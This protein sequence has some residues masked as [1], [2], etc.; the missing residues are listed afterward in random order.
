MSDVVKNTTCPPEALPPK[1][2]G[3]AGGTSELN[4][5]YNDK[6]DTIL[7]LPTCLRKFNRVNRDTDKEISLEKLELSVRS[8]TIPDISIPATK[9]A[10]GVGSHTEAGTKYDDFPDIDIQFKMDDNMSNYWSI[11]KWMQ[12]LVDIEKGVVGGFEK[13]HY[14][15]T[16]SVFLLGQYKKPIG[17]YTF[18]GVVPTKLGGYPLDNNTEGDVIYIDFSFAYDRMTFDLRTDIDN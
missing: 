10:Y 13:D 18:H 2:F 4:N 8:I 11:Y 9:V 12:M 3:S 17:L 7:D 5:L 6:F 14:S 1:I 15:T 16:Y